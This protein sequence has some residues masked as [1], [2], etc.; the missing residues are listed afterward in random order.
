MEALFQMSNNKDLWTKPIVRIPFN[1]F[2]EDIFVNSMAS[3][4]LMGYKM[5][6]K[7]ITYKIID[8]EINKN[9]KL[10]LRKQIL[11]KNQIYYNMIENI[12]TIVLNIAKEYYDDFIKNKIEFNETM[13]LDELSQFNET[14]QLDES[15]QF[16]ET[17]YISSDNDEFNNMI[18]LDAPILPFTV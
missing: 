16:N 18:T 17:I 4:L 2:D 6:I 8:Q 9:K 15:S 1:S 13:Q 3:E 11:I 14:M 5:D 10:D 12:T 7:R